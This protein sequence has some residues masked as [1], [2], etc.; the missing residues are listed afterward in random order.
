MRFRSSL[1]AAVGVALLAGCAGNSSPQSGSLPTVQSQARVAQAGHGPVSLVSAWMLPAGAQRLHIPEGVAQ[2]AKKAKGGIYGGEFYG[3][4]SESEGLIN[5]Y[6]DPDNKN[7]KPTCTINGY[8]I[9][10]FGIDNNGDL[11]LPSSTDSTA[12]PSVNVYA[13]PG[14]CGKLLGSIPDT[15][16]Q[17]SDAKSSDATNQP[18]YVGE[19]VNATSGVGDIVICTL[20]SKT[21]GNPVTSPKITGYGGGVAVDAKGNC[22]LDAGTS[23]TTGFELIY[24]K[25]CKGAGKVATGT[26]NTGLGGI[27]FDASG[28]L[29]TID[30]N[31]ELYVYKGCNPKC[32]LVS[33]SPLQG[34]S[35]FGNLNSDGTQLAVGDLSNSDIDVYT[36]KSTGLT[37]SYSF[38]NGLN[39]T[40]STEAG[41]FDPT[42]KM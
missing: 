19:I 23:S 28:N 33:S 17:A 8:A 10:G 3:D 35:I 11:I 30:V 41:G 9:N 38:N 22:W 4:P 27:F 39:G 32:K 29:A 34:A 7:V 24:W 36:Y 12:Q 5:G 2:P 15:T 25:G 6:P 42:N 26:K 21:C 14:L 18:I 37:Y 40:G 16:G 1:Y 20:K 13:G 31:G